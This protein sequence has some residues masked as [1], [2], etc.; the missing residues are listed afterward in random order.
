MDSVIHWLRQNKSHVVA[1]IVKRIYAELPDYRQRSLE[2]MTVGAAMAYDQWCSTV[3]HNDLMRHAAQAQTVIQRN[4]AHNY[5]PAQVTR[6]PAIICEVVLT[7]L[8]QAEG[9]VNPSERTLFHTR[10]KRMT[11]TILGVGGMKIAGTYLQKTI[12]DSVPESPTPH[13]PSKS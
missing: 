4:I 2:E 10:A 6:V 3:E 1:Q 12:G 8:D 11:A 5:D 7:L 13:D 9:S